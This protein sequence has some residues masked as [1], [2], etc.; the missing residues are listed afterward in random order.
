MSTDR[1]PS[2]SMSMQADPSSLE[3]LRSHL[4]DLEHRAEVLEYPSVTDAEWEA[5]ITALIA[6]EL[7]SGAP[8]LDSP[9]LRR[10]HTVQTQLE[11]TSHSA[12]WPAHDAVHSVA[13]LRNHHRGHARADGDV[14]YVASA[15]VPG[16]DVALRYEE[17]VLT[18]A[19]SRGDGLSGA[20]VTANIRTLPTIPL[21]LRPAGSTTESRATK[22]S[23]QGLGPSTLTPTPAFPSAFEVKVRVSL[24]TTDLVALD[25][26]RV[27]AGE[28]PFVLAT[29]AVQDSLQSLDPRVPA[30][31]RL[32]AFAVDTDAGNLESQWQLL[33]ALKS[34]GFAI[35]PLTWRCKGLQ[36]VLD[37]VNSLQQVAP[38][39]DYPLEGGTLTVNRPSPS[40]NGGAPRTIKLVF[41]PGGRGG[42]VLKTYQAVGRTG[43]VLPV[44][45]LG[46][47]AD[48]SLPLPERAPVPAVENGLL[49]LQEG[50]SVRVRPG[51]V[52][53]IVTTTNGQGRSPPAD[54]VCASCGEPPAPR[55]PD[56]LFRACSASHCPGRARALL[57]HLVGPRGLKIGSLGVKTI[58]RLL[59]EHGPLDLP[60]LLS[61]DPEV[62]ER[63][64]PGQG[65]NFAREQARHRT[66]PL[67]KVLHLAGIP[68]LGEH[69]ARA[70]AQQAFSAGRLVE[71]GAEVRRLRQA[72]PEALD[73]LADWL[74]GPGPIFLEAVRRARVEILDAR[75]T[76]PAP[77]L[78]RTVVVDGRFDTG[79]VQ[80][81]DEVE[82]RGGR[83]QS[84]VGRTT[85]LVILGDHADRTRNMAAMYGVPVLDEAAYQRLERST[86]EGVVAV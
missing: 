23:Q 79:A 57:V 43:A 67:W 44:V 76:F 80:V 55:G 45:Q 85:D 78:D 50:T 68:Y 4:R 34:W 82:R 7:D 30:S 64:A 39:F 17:G 24:R 81:A 47:S 38:T 3:E 2:S 11:P 31:R 83:L 59:T 26:R 21:R 32:R 22:P 84:R 8:P 62:I 86:R 19:V 14:V 12:P 72:D 35:V 40:G 60:G 70:I 61:L 5:L 13:E 77:F 49:V 53:P 9:A 37:F 15:T 58:D 75:A 41:P 27:D 20:D 46:R 73:A 18:R 74:G 25:R 66:L 33:G 63:W 48:P 10:L 52:A 16:V 69:G 29:G 1:A 56:R 6:R 71:L 54:R 51:G 65:S 42:V 28:P 36:E